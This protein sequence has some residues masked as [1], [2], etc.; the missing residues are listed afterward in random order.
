MMFSYNKTIEFLYSSLPVYH[1]QGKSAYKANLDNIQAL[2]DHFG[3]PH[4]RF[5]TIHIAGTNGK[6]SVSHMLASVLQQSG[7]KTGLYTSPHLKDYRERIRVN[8]KMIAKRDVVTFVNDNIEI[9]E[10]LK[11][12]FFEIS[13]A[14]AYKYFADELVD[15]AVVETGLGGRLDATNIIEPVLSVITNIG[16]DHLD[17]LGDTL[18]KVAIE[19]AGIIKNGI[20]VVVGEAQPDVMGV[21][22]QTADDKGAEIL[23]ADKYFMCELHEYDIY[24]KN[25]GF[26]LRNLVNGK[27]NEGITPLQGDYQLK[28][29]QTVFAAAEVLKRH[30]NISDKN[31]L[32]GIRKTV[33]TTG[34]KGRWQVIGKKPLTICD[35]GHNIEGLK[36]VIKHINHINPPAVHFVMGFVNDKDVTSILKLFPPEWTCYFTRASIPRALDEAVLKEIAER[37][38]LHGDCYGSV[39]E[40]MEAAREAAG[41]NDLVF[42]GGSTFVVAEVV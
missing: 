19:K 28:N 10:R 4:R 23:F 37:E 7:L 27:F 2:D 12:S 5:R 42:I 32:S 17:I 25:R 11:P 24:D 31:I 13:V 8:G 15:V 20:P 21:F 9:I 3:H 35:T 22:M 39:K 30:F 33:T 14:L 36:Y 38:G 6:G 1:N 26:T 40:A 18:V 16:H 41:D 34:L 29:I